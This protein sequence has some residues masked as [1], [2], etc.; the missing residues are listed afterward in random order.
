MLERLK[1]ADRDTELFTFLC[2]GNGQVEAILRAAERVGRG[3]H[4][5]RIGART[6]LSDIDGSPVVDRGWVFAISHSG[7]LVALEPDPS[8]PTGQALCGK[9]RAAPELVHHEER[10]LYPLRRL[11][12]KGDPEPRWERIG[13][14]EALDTIAGQMT[15]IAA[16]S[17][18]E[19]VAFALTT[20]S[21]TA[22]SDSLQWIERLLRAFGSSNNCYG[23]EICNWHKD[24]A[25]EYT[26]GVGI[27]R[28]DLDQ[29]GCILLWGHNP[30]TS[31][32]AQAQR[33]SLVALVGALTLGLV[34]A[35]AIAALWRPYRMVRL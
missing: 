31:W 33:V 9:G 29:A 35:A 30:N 28:P 34:L 12:P 5:G 32:L 24:H 25:T 26:Y 7:R 13:W 6:T 20:P 17:G 4:Q 23:T 27:G 15:R 14:D 16:E 10:L 2:I 1:A 18:P 8:H 11:S 21:G 22:I 3:Q 19:S